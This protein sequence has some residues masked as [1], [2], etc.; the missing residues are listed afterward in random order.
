MLCLTCLPRK[1]PFFVRRGTTYLVRYFTLILISAYMM[2]QV[3]HDFAQSYT[4]WLAERPEFSNIL[5]TLSFPEQ[6]ET[7]RKPI[8]AARRSTAS[9]GLL[10]PMLAA[11]TLNERAALAGAAK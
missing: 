2:Q 9:S 8:A 1:K 7:Q 4:E 3:Q 5:A 6:L 11:A 10:S